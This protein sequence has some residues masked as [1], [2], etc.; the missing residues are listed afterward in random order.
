MAKPPRKHTVEERAAYNNDQARLDREASLV[1]QNRK[2]LKQEGISRLAESNRKRKCTN[3]DDDLS[4]VS[5][6]DRPKELQGHNAFDTAPH[7]ETPKHRRQRKKPADIYV[8]ENNV[9]SPTSTIADSPLAATTTRTNTSNITNNDSDS[10]SDND[11]SEKPLIGSRVAVL[12]G[13]VTHFGKVI[14]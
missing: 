2:Q 9:G 5:A 6:T 1:D 3:N 14:S 10:E 12:R 13:S 11:I 4:V 8:P 7:W